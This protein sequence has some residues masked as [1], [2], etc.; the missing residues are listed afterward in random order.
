M[1]PGCGV[2]RR[3]SGKLKGENNL[4]GKKILLQISLSGAVYGV[5]FLLAFWC[6]ILPATAF[7]VTA[8]PSLVPE[9][10]AVLGETVTADIEVM[11]DVSS[12]SEFI[13]VYT[14]LGSASWDAVIIDDGREMPIGTRRG[15]YLTIT[16]FELYNPGSSVTKLQVHLK[17][18]VPEY[19]SGSGDAEVITLEHIAGDGSTVLDSVTENIAIID[20]AAVN[21]I[22]IETENGLIRFEEEINGAYSAGTDTSAAEEA[23]ADVRDLIDA[24]RQMDIQNASAALSEAQEILNRE[25]VLL[26]NSVTQYNYHNARGMIAA[27][28]PAI[29]EYRDAGGVDEQ[30]I[31]VVLSYRDNAEMLLVLAQDRDSLGD[32]AGAQRYATDAYKKA[33]NA[34]AY[35]AGMYTDAGLTMRGYTP[36]ATVPQPY[37]EGSASTS[38]HTLSIPDFTGSAQSEGIQ[39]IDVGGTVGLFQEILDGCMGFAGFLQDVAGAFSK[40]SG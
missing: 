17:G 3:L 32:E 38:S 20:V 8:G 15:R 12:M 10:Q 16:G 30:G 24:S 26:T 14:D 13:T 5:L 28:V 31:L 18:V 25:F 1:L 22:R 19:L 11:Y 40:I 21:V 6:C 9:E 23:A 34:M 37:S 4:N 7:T 35:L 2:C 33:D 29:A 39:V 27:I 36:A